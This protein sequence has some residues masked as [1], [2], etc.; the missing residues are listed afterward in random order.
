MSL[1]NTIKT[2]KGISFIRF[3]KYLIIIDTLLI[4]YVKFIPNNFIKDREKT[5]STYDLIKVYANR[6][7]HYI[8]TLIAILYPFIVK[9]T[10]SMDIIYI[11][12]IST[13][14]ILWYWNGGCVISEHEKQI[15]NPSYKKGENPDYQPFMDVMIPMY[16][17]QTNNPYH[18]FKTYIVLFYVIARTIY[19][20]L[21]KK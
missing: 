8:L 10:I 4:L 16:K 7:I 18:M 2:F 21:H 13:I 1:Y 11:L 17:K 3:L 6:F 12:F 5:L 20:I 15:L 14:I 9:Y 19:H